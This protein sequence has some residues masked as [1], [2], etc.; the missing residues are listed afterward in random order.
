MRIT[1]SRSARIRAALAREQNGKCFYCH[2]R[3]HDDVT[4][5]HVSGRSLGGSN[6]WSNLAA[7]HAKCNSLVGSLP[8]AEKLR[9]REIGRVLGSDAFFQEAAALA[10]SKLK[11]TFVQEG[12]KIVV[13]KGV[14]MEFLDQKLADNKRIARQEA[15]VQRAAWLAGCPKHKSPSRAPVEASQKQVGGR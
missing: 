6:A 3:M 5:E 7:A 13:R 1:K 2:L 4:L 12:N 10:G 11:K 8:M 15:R 14:R 9:L